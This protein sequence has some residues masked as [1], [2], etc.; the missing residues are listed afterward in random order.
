MLAQQDLACGLS[1]GD[2]H[3][4]DEETSVAF[5]L[6]QKEGV[7]LVDAVALFDKLNFYLVVD[8]LRPCDSNQNHRLAIGRVRLPFGQSTLPGIHSGT[9]VRPPFGRASPDSW[10]IPGR[11]GDSCIEALP[12]G[13]KAPVNTEESIL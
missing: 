9:S 1:S 11:H 2:W 3:G 8:N 12:H 5:L 4:V 10:W 13:S 6:W 7:S